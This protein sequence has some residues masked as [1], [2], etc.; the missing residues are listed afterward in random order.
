MVNYNCLRCGYETNIKTILVRHLSRKIPCKAIYEDI[1]TE[2][3]KQKLLDNEYTKSVDNVNTLSTN[4]VKTT[5]H[6][7][8]LTQNEP[9]LNHNP[10]KFTQNEP[11]LTKNTE[12]LTQ[13]EPIL[14]QN[15][16]L[17]TQKRIYECKYCEKVYSTNSHLNRHLKS[18]KEKAKDDDQK[19]NL[20]HL[21][22]MLNLQLNEQKEQLKR[23][24]EQLN[25]E[26][27]RRDKQIEEQNKQINE[28]IKKAG[29]TQNIQNIQNNFKV[30]AYKNTDL[31]HLT[32]Q[33]YIQCLNRS[34]MVI[35][36]LIKKIHFNP[37]KPENHN[38]YISNI[39]NKYVMIYDG[40]KWDL[41]S[42]DETIDDLIDTNEMVIEQKLEE[43]LENG[44][45]YPEIMKKFNRYLEKKEKD[46][47]INKI[48]EEI[49]L[50]LFNN[51]NVI[52]KD[53]KKAI[54]I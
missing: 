6:I 5:G 24:D 16:H 38:I 20:L 40:T 33:D 43:W 28:L 25:E 52:D 53:S 19:A 42:R 12:I 4:Y 36:N 11:I 21:V 8:N 26:L 49:R 45:E 47:V 48:K 9:I 44:K 46:E 17:L 13:N 18:C 30:L 32:D 3:L 14:T 23:R 51:R 41:C 37:K 10:K 29:I 27:K 35:P 1:P 54:D 39:K 50:I 31:S 34:N 15:D 2:H 22:D 7:K